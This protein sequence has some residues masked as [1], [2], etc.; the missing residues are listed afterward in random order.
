[1][2]ILAVSGAAG[3]AVEGSA[4]AR[5]FL[6]GVAAYRE[7][8]YGAAAAAFESLAASGIRNS[9]LYYNLGNAYL[10]KGDL[11]PALLWYERALKLDPDDP[12]LNFNHAY[13][14]SLTTDEREEA[15]SVSI[16]RILFFWRHLLSTRMTA[17]LAIGLNALFWLVLAIRFMGG[18]KALKGVAYPLLLVALVFTATALYD[19]Y[20]ATYIRE[21]IV[22]P[23]TVSVRSGLSEEATELFVLHA[24]AKVTIEQEKGDFFRIRFSE[25]K[26]GWVNRSRIGPV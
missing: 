6:E 15:R 18:K 10:K 4:G 11:G 14:R 9:R 16:Y 8:D 21:G 7:G 24:G 17:A 2:G 22:L 26:I 19:Y 13:A 5:T 3:A 20:E 1:M 23:E 25:G 12:D